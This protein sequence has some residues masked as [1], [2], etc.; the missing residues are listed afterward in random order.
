MYFVSLVIEG[1]KSAGIEHPYQ[2]V[3][4]AVIVRYDGEYGLF[5]VSHEPQFHVIP[6]S[7]AHNLRQ[8]EGGEADGCLDQNTF[9]GFAG[10]LFENLIFPNSDMAGVLILQSLKKQA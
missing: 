1:L 7:N 4:G 2:V 5:T 8:D 3:E 6:A 10:G 9:G